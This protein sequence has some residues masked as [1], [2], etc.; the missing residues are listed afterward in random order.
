VAC[1]I[2]THR[3]K[4]ITLPVYNLQHPT[5]NLQLI[6]RNNFYDWKMSVIS[7]T[8]IVADFSG[9]FYTTPPLDPKYTGDSLS[10]VYFEG[11]PSDLVFPYYSQTDG[12]Q[13]SAEIS[14]DQE[15]WT[16]VFLI[17]RS[18]EAVKPLEWAV[19]DG[20][21]RKHGKDGRISPAY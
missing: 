14:T 12:T 20:Y 7:Q 15:L 19:S 1:V 16:S 4:S 10:P 6:L 2:S 11:F 9:L 3:S 18:L 17:M 13:W 21:K 8:P 5:L